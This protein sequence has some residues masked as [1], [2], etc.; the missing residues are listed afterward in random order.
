MDM[1]ESRTVVRDTELLAC[2]ESTLGLGQLG[3]RNH[4]HRL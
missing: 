2:N 4:L 3:G 1:V